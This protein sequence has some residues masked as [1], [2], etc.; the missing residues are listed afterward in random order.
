MKTLKSY[1]L[2]FVGLACVTTSA[3]ATV[4]IL[5]AET[6]D[7]G[8][9]FHSQSSD[10]TDPIPEPLSGSG[11][12]LMS[13]SGLDS[14]ALKFWDL[15]GTRATVRYVQSYTSGVQFNFDGL[16]EG[17]S[18]QNLWRFGA[19]G[20]NLASSGGTAVDIRLRGDG[21]LLVN[22]GGG[23]GFKT[24]SVGLNTRFSVSL[25]MNAAPSGGSSI[26]YDQNGTTVSLDPQHYSLYVD[27]SLVGTYQLLQSTADI[28]NVWF[29]TGTGGANEGATMQIDNYE[30]R[31]G[32]DISAI[33]EPTT[34][35]F[36]AGLAGLGLA[37]LRR[38]RQS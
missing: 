33:P 6:Y 30:V 17:G 11:I 1:L 7:K 8:G 21:D 24:V 20:A 32:A 10:L 15:D 35:A 13:S 14:N 34:Y 29:L 27:D 5:F 16:I 18:A 37:I 22:Q 36:I 2:P 28:G 31:T 23:N 9:V 25:V 26:S 12:G 3:H 4:V 38:R 19:T